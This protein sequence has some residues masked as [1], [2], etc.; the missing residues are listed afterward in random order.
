MKK[1]I[2]L[3]L[4]FMACQEGQKI[5][6]DYK[7]FLYEGHWCLDQQKNKCYRF[8]PKSVIEKKNGLDVGILPFRLLSFNSKEK[9]LR[10]RM[11]NQ[12]EIYIFKINNT[13]EIT[14]QIENLKRPSQ[15]LFRN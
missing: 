12:R 11:F 10:V 8:Q 14:F 2:V 3:I 4:F 6:I 1:W 13:N 9:T 5:S 15:K 7:T